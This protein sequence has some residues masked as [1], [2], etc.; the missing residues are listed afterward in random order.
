MKYRHLILM[1]TALSLIAVAFMP[2]VAAENYSLVML[3]GKE[4]GQ[5]ILTIYTDGNFDGRDAHDIT[6]TYTDIR[7]NSITITPVTVAYAEGSITLY[8]QIG[9]EVFPQ[10]TSSHAD[11]FVGVL[12]DTFT[13]S[14]PGWGWASIH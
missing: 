12:G 5:V 9:R 8:L 11:G 3:G 10:V 7:Y 13:A 4:K 1:L 14:G 2:A 6:L